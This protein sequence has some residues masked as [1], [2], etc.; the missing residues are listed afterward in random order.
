[1]RLHPEPFEMIKAKI[2]KVEYRL[3]DEKRKEIEIGDTITFYKRPEEKETIKATVTNKK[4]YKNLQEMYTDTFD[5]YLK[6]YYKSP[7]DVVKDTSYY[8]D[9]EVEKN[10][11]VAI[12]IELN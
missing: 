11:C 2:K 4:Y 12:F 6:D 1:M 10:G 3:N 5:M 8:T 9:E 7:I